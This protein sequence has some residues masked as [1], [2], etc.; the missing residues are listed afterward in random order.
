M[1]QGNASLGLYQAMQVEKQM[2]LIQQDAEKYLRLSSL[3]VPPDEISQQQLFFTIVK[4]LLDN[5][6][7]GEI[8]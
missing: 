2:G 6:L 3:V 7:Q 5:S 1:R 4:L 8:S